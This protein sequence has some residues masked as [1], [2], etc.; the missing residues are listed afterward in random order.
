MKFYWK[1]SLPFSA[2][3]LWIGAGV[4]WLFQMVQTYSDFVINDLGYPFSWYIV[5]VKIFSTYFIWVLLAPGVYQLSVAYLKWATDFKL[6]TLPGLIFSS[7][8]CI[9]VH[10]VLTTACR[11]LLNYFS[12]GYFTSWFQPNRRA[13]FV[14]TG[15]SSTAQY[16]L[17]TVFFIAIEYYQ[18]YQEKER[19]LSEA[20][21]KALLMQLQPHF[22]FNTLHSI[23][24]LIDWDKKGA[25]KMITRLG[26][27]LRTV[28]NSEDK[29]MVTLAEEIQ[30]L[31]DYLEIEQVRFQ[32]RLELDIQIDAASLQAR[33]P[34]LLLQP[35]VENAIRHGLASRTVGGE[36]SIFARQ[37]NGRADQYFLEISIE[38][39]GKGFDHDVQSKER[40][41]VGLK[42]VRNRLKQYYGESFDFQIATQPGMGCSVFIRIPFEKKV[43]EAR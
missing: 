27:L 15:F 9:L 23:A 10:I 29:P 6:A 38:D 7:F 43:E 19:E 35:I 39:N 18:K 3:Y 1:R 31:E 32:D 24:S 36:L 13:G 41:G 4:L 25:Q 33:L 37:T 8:I 17:F 20:R 21:L 12:L 22:L 11:D 30:F 16:L 28:L 26:N 2:F 42:N 40:R 14:A 34:N 5:G